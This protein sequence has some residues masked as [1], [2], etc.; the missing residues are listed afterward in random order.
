MPFF[1]GFYTEKT[2]NFVSLASGEPSLDPSKP[3]LLGF[4]V[5]AFWRTKVSLCPKAWQ[6]SSADLWCGEFLVLDRDHSMSA[7]HRA[8]RGLTSSSLCPS[9]QS[10]AK[11]FPFVFEVLLQRSDA[12]KIVEISFL[13]RL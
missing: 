9:S 6:C 13:Q 2:R 10:G 1:C 8:N 5:L 3:F 4:I 12:S 11:S 7:P